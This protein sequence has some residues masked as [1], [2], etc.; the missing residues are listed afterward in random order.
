VS[1]EA[2]IKP[3]RDTPK[4]IANLHG[5]KSITEELIYRFSGSYMPIFYDIQL[6]NKN[7]YTASVGNYKFDTTL[8]EF[9][10]IKERKIR[11]VNHKG[12]VLKLDNV[13]DQKSIYP[14]VEEFGYTTVN[15]FIFKSSWD[16]GYHYLTSNNPNVITAL[17]SKETMI[18]NPG[19]IG[20]QTPIQN[21][22]L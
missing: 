21:I 17:Q 12:S 11:K 3:N 13:K 6:F 5:S 2:E 19:L 7:F 16:L 22:S 1:I 4:P 18:K 10:L 15:S 14:M 20:I 8:T 9:G